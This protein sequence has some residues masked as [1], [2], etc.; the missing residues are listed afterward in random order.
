MENKIN[1]NVQDG[2]ERLIYLDLMRIFATFTV[3]ILHASA[4]NWLD[5]PTNS[6]QVQIGLQSSSDIL[7]T[8]DEY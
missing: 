3:I 2:S 4:Q 1:V 5:V 7:K 8:A 6:L